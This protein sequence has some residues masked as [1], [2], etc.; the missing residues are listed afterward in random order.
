MTGLRPDVRTFALCG[1]EMDVDPIG[2]TVQRSPHLL[3]AYLPTYLTARSAQLPTPCA[4]SAPPQPHSAT[5][6]AAESSGKQHWVHHRWSCPKFLR[7]PFTNERCT[8]WLPKPSSVQMLKLSHYKSLMRLCLNFTACVW[9]AE[10]SEPKWN[11]KQQSTSPCHHRSRVCS[12]LT[13]NL[14]SN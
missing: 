7:R 6:N 3:F 14:P 9:S 11:S 2:C 12:V 10:R 8:R 1:E 13:R 5:Q 4:L